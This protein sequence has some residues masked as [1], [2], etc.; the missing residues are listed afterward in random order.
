[1]H[2]MISATIDDGDK[3]VVDAT[4]RTRPRIGRSTASR[5]RCSR[6]LHG[7]RVRG[8]P[9]KSLEI[10]GTG[11]RAELRPGS[12]LLLLNVGSRI[13][14]ASNCSPL[15]APR[16]R[17]RRPPRLHNE[18]GIDKQIVGQQAALI[19]KQ[20]PPEPYRGKGIRYQGEVGPA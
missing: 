4:R 17:W 12:N 9:R 7:E 1:M 15:R 8:V 19:R 11:Y 10:Q 18:V 3:I 2:P 14:G 16:L 13:P 5:A 6:T 20:R